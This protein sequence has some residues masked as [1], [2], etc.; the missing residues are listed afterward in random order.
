MNFQSGVTFA[1]SVA[2]TTQ[3]FHFLRCSKDQQK[4][5]KGESVLSF[6]LKWRHGGRSKWCQAGSLT[7]ERKLLIQ[8]QS[9]RTPFTDGGTL[10]KSQNNT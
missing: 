5:T 2:M 10:I 1:A 7:T 4:K 9:E 8:T 3:V 6:T